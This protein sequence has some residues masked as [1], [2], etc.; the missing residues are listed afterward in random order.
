MVF[1]FRLGDVLVVVF[2]FT[3]GCNLDYFVDVRHGMVGHATTS[4]STTASRRR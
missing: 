2:T 1:W 3:A 4:T